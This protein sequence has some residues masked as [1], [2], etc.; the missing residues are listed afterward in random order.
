MLRSCHSPNTRSAIRRVTDTT[1][2]VFH[3][4]ID[5]SAIASNDL[6]VKQHKYGGSLASTSVSSRIQQHPCNPFQD[7]AHQQAFRII[8][9]IGSIEHACV[10]EGIFLNPQKSQILSSDQ[11]KSL[12]ATIPALRQGKTAIV[13]QQS[14]SSQNHISPSLEKWEMGKERKKESTLELQFIQKPTF[15]TDGVKQFCPQI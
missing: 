9:S 10:Y 7:L 12:K 2:T 3:D 5:D 8:T 13:D 4:G 15:C 6:V 11:K 1:S 14:E